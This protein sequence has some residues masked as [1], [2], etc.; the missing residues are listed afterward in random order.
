[1]T[2]TWL[3]LVLAGCSWAHLSLAQSGDAGAGGLGAAAGTTTA[4]SGTKAAAATGAADASGTTPGAAAPASPAPSAAETPGTG[5]KPK[6]S[7]APTPA[8]PFGFGETPPGTPV[9]SSLL[10][11]GGSGATTTFGLGQQKPGTSPIVA[12]KVEG[13]GAAAATQTTPRET[14]TTFTAPGF[15]GEG[16]QQFTSG[17]GRFTRPRYRYGA[18]VS[19]GFDDNT[20]QTPDGGGAVAGQEQSF[21]IPA[22]PEV[23]QIVNVREV[24]GTR[25]T[26]G[27]FFVTTFRIVPR[28]V[29]LRPAQDEQVIVQRIPGI[30]GKARNASV[31]TNLDAN[32]DVQWVK[33]RSALT[34]DLHGGVDYYWTRPGTTADYNGSLSFAYVRRVT[35]RMQFSTNT[36]LTYQAQPDYTRVNLQQQGIGSGQGNDQSSGAYFSGNTKYDLNYRW[37][38]RFSTDTSFSLNTILYSDSGRKSSNFWEALLGNEFQYLWSS[39][40]SL[41]GELR[42][43]VTRYLD[44]PTHDSN[45]V[46]LLVGTNYRLSRRAA[47]TFR[48]GQSLRSY[49][50]G[51]ADGSTPYGEGALNYQYS[52]RTAFSVNG[53]YGFEESNN[54]GDQ[55][56]VGRIGLNYTHAFTPRLSSGLGL[57]FIHNNSSSSRSNVTSMSKIY[58]LNASLGYRFSRHFSVSTRYSYTLNAT[59]TGDNDYDRSRFFV[60]GQ[61]EF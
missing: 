19:M 39:R 17:Q 47:L 46:Y 34:F 42:Y 29:V 22:Q 40:L 30:A 6:G 56:T 32:I 21:P 54:P 12:D 37:G 27:G 5:A 7:D 53:R 1:M 48:F 14:S 3:T 9:Q 60:T 61:Y 45:T 58:D 55:S 11:P 4:P 41:I 15:F 52:S 44:A 16:Q 49:S 43:G 38:H 31:V 24:T 57:N 13:A 33:S 2:R 8:N 20:L 26:P 10:K 35:S 51:G 25:F 59:S 18:S 36:S 23:S 50:Q 28:R